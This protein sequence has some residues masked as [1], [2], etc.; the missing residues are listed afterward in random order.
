MLAFLVSLILA[1]PAAPVS[2][3]QHP[4][5]PLSIGELKS[6]ATTTAAKYHLTKTQTDRMLATIS[7]ESRWDVD[8]ESPTNDVGIVQINR[9]AHPYVTEEEMRD[10]YFSLDFMAKNFSKHP[11]WWVCYNNLFGEA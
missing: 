2:V 10:P 5:P 11:N 8:I 4:Q 6:L 7:C 3:V 1:I 9:D